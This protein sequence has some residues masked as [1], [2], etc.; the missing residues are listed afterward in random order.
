MTF[1]VFQNVVY[2]LE[3]V[4][5]RLACVAWRCLSSLKALRKRWS[6]DEERQSRE[7]PG[8]ETNEVAQG[9]AALCT[10]V[11]I[12]HFRYIKIQHGSEA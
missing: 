7:E 3:P 5:N 6:L 4:S 9:F 11:Q 10:R 1:N 8:R 2:V 12:D